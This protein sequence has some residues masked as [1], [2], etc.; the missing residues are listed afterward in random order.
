MPETVDLEGL[1]DEVLHRDPAPVGF[2]SIL[3]LLSQVL[4]EG[5][6]QVN[7]MIIIDTPL[8]LALEREVL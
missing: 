5:G 2:L 8:Q 4:L 7:L 6:R 1:E 3:E